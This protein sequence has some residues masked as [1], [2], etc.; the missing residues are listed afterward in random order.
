[1]IKR[2]KF[3]LLRKKCSLLEL[4]EL[5]SYILL[6]EE[7]IFTV[8]YLFWSPYAQNKSSK[9]GLNKH[10]Y[11]SKPIVLTKIQKSAWAVIVILVAE[12]LLL[13][14]LSSCVRHPKFMPR[15]S[16]SETDKA[17]MASSRQEK[18]GSRDKQES[19]CL[20]HICNIRVLLWRLL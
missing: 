8:W 20:W 16:S 2:L 15:Y 19:N 17:H 9:N 10:L 4:R 11:P 18:L 1:M 6:K 7:R 14:I 5:L 12:L 13:S 3:H